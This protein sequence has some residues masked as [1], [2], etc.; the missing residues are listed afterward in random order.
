MI[1][2]MICSC[3]YPVQRLG[4]ANNLHIVVRDVKKV[5]YSYILKSSLNLCLNLP[6]TATFRLEK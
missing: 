5:Q 6:A 2:Y 1:Y 4:P 3:I